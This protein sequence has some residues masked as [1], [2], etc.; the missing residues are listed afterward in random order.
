MKKKL[1]TILSLVLAFVLCFT[2]VA[3]GGDESSKK[4]GKPSGGGKPEGED[5][6][7]SESTVSITL[8]QALDVIDNVLSVHGFTGEASYT[9][10]TKNTEALT[11]SAM[12]DKRGNKLKI[13]V[14]TDEH[15]VDMATGYV[16]RSGENGYTYDQAINANVVGYIQYVISNLDE[17]VGEN[18]VSAVYDEKAKTLTFAVDKSESVNKYLAPIQKA[19]KNN[20]KIG[21]LLDDYCKLLFGKNFDS[22]YKSFE[23]Y[24]GNSKNTVGTLLD[25]L[26]A[27]GLDVEAILEMTGYGLP[28]DQMNHIKARPLNQVVAG[29]FNYLMN[30]IGGLMPTAEEDEDDIDYEYGGMQSFGLGLLNAM[31]FEEVTEKDVKTAMDGI[32]GLLTFVKTFDVKNAVDLA[33]AKNDKTA[34][35]YTVIKN[36]VQLDAA[37]VTVT[38]TVDE[39]KKVKGVKVDCFAA[40]T[41][42]G[43][44]EGGMLLSDN[45]YRATAELVI[46]EYK[47]STEDFVITLDPACDYK[48]PVVALLYEVTDKSVSVY[49]ETAGKTVTVGS[50]ILEV[51]TP[52]GKT[53]QITNAAAD[54]FKF[55]AATS[56]FV[57]DGAL[58]KSAL[59][60]AAF[61][62][63][64]NAIVF[65]DEDDSGYAVTLTYVNADLQGLKDYARE[66]LLALLQDYIGDKLPQS[67]NVAVGQAA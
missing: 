22:M 40:H 64:L 50:Y 39:D 30:N 47:T 6:P 19:Y 38:I 8:N 1:I 27:Q 65:F 34:E 52:E 15:I 20:K 33:L 41:Y 16:Y 17:T 26:K 42:N 3:C 31:L 21:A 32:G 51:E 13:T 46:D 5:P 62:T 54:A 66:S 7:A 12:L 10:S 9:L 29:A 44:F 61:G 56:S 43:K 18:N 48:M 55:D 60:D 53:E 37:S 59:G 57:F 67:P 58:V 11:E 28:A 25:A 23:K 4:P 63:S 14:G 24:V 2:L 49:Y 45:D 35:M 36:G